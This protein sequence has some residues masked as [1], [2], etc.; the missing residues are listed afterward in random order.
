M[1]LVTRLVQGHGAFGQ[2]HGLVV[3]AAQLRDGGLVHVG[4]RQHVVGAERR[5]QPLGVA[6]RAGRV[7]VAALL[8][9]HHAR[10]RMHLRQV[11]PVAGGMQRGRRFGQVF[12]DDR[13][14]ADLLVAEHELE[15]RQ[16]DAAR[17]V[18]R[19]RVFERARVQRNRARLFA[20][21]IGDAA[22]QAPQRREQGLRDLFANLIRRAA[23]HRGG[24]LRIALEQPRFREG[25][26]NHQLVETLEGTGLQ[27]RF[28]QV[29]RRGSAAPVE[30]RGGACQRRLQG[31]ADHRC[32]YTP[33]DPRL[34]APPN[35]CSLDG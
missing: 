11:P 32:E 27:Q 3:A 16:P 33:R 17:V 23:E 22:V 8:G 24:A 20:D 30:Q 15:V 14:V 1:R 2:C 28:E 18:R 10:H 19:F 26:A 5:G 7:L 21:G 12:A 13:V 35:A 25:A 31:R 9:E 29:G 34:S 4:Q 6:Q